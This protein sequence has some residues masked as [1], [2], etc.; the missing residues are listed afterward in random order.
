L[1]EPRKALLTV[2]DDPKVAAEVMGRAPSVDPEAEKAAI[3]KA[4]GADMAT[5]PGFAIAANGVLVAKWIRKK[6]GSFVTAAQTQRE[7]GWQGKIGL[8]LAL[9]P[10]AFIDDGRY[11]FAGFAAKIGDWVW[12]TSTDG[13]DQDFQPTGSFERV[14]FRLLRDFE[15]RG[16]VPRPDFFY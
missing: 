2:A 7:D 4:I 9:G 8:V 5:M 13:T 14:P 10:S 15:I 1:S 12:Y 3:I 11:T 16:K 6:I